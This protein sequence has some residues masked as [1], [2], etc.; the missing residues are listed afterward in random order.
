MLFTGSRGKNH[1]SD[2]HDLK[3]SC[4][5]LCWTF[6]NLLQAKLKVSPEGAVTA[7]LFLLSSCLIFF[8][9]CRRSRLPQRNRPGLLRSPE[10]AQQATAS[11]PE[12]APVWG[13][14]KSRSVGGPQCLRSSGTD[15]QLGLR[16]HSQ[17]NAAASG[18]AEKSGSSRRCRQTT[19][20]TAKTRQPSDREVS[21]ER[22]GGS[23]NVS[24]EWVLTCSGDTVSTPCI[25]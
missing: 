9:S 6:T 14:Q 12:P 18:H 1:P 19:E 10:S 25:N 3:V 15:Q 11:N 22:G 24:S 23:F 17:P 5:L 4:L 21:G 16:C 20:Q 7:T 8:L 13:R 2:I